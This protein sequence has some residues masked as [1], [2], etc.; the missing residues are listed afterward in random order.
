MYCINSNSITLHTL[1]FDGEDNEILNLNS[2]RAAKIDIKNL[3]KI[4][5]ANFKAYKDKSGGN[6]AFVRECSLMDM[7][8]M[9]FLRAISDEY[10]GISV[11]DL[12]I[13]PQNKLPENFNDFRL[14][15]L[16]LSP[17]VSS[18][19]VFRASFEMPDLTSKS[20]F[21]KFKFNA[22]MP[23]FR[24]LNKMDNSHILSFTDFESS[25]IDF[26][27]FQK[28]S[29]NKL[30]TGTLITKTKINAGDILMKRHFEPISLVKKGDLLSAVLSDGGLSIIIEV[31]ALESG[32]LGDIIKIR[33]KDNKIIKASVASKTQV[34]LR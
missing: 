17:Q 9:Q 29:L 33:T 32:N 8:Q 26:N 28:D 22:K 7:L 15:N 21:F 14:Q 10:E 24:A 19:G 12:I 27:K 11:L 23:V 4:L 1:G 30:P 2:H 20:L 18:S 16:F 6:V 3:N 13:E 5:N 31:R 25:M 34:I